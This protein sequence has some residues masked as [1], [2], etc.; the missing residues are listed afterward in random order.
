MRAI[1]TGFLTRGG[2]KQIFFLLPSKYMQNNF[3][4]ILLPKV[5]IYYNMKLHNTILC[6]T[7]SHMYYYIF[8]TE[9]NLLFSQPLQETFPKKLNPA[10]IPHLPLI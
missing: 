8:L 4:I 5:Y 6:S 1:E 10:I 7:M 3:T 9:R 2:E